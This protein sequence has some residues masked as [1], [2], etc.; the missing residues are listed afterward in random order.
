M[1]LLK[2]LL[3]AGLFIIFYSYAGYGV[4]VWFLIKV[5]FFFRGRQVAKAVP[6]VQELPAVTLVIAAYNEESFILEK[7]NNSLSLDYPE[8]KLD[9]LFITDGSTDQTPQL[10]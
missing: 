1:L 9:I 8:D 7:I 5:R 3:F 6:G 2:L 10:V 4:L